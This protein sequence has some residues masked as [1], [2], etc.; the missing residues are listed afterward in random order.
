MANQSNS[1]WQR[2]SRTGAALHRPI[3][4]GSITLTD[5]ATAADAAIDPIMVVDAEAVVMYA[6]RAAHELVGTAN[7]V[8]T[9]ISSA[10]RVRGGHEFVD[11]LGSNAQ[12][13][14]ATILPAEGDE[15]EAELS[16]G[17]ADSA[18]NPRWVVV[19]HPLPR[20]E[21]SIREMLRRATHDDLTALANRTN[22]L[23]S[24]DATLK[25]PRTASGDHVLALIDLDG[26]KDINDSW[27]HEV[28]DRVLMEIG[29]RLRRLCRPGDVVA[30]LGGDEFAAWC[31]WVDPGDA[32]KL[33]TRL[34]SMF[35]DP[36]ASLDIQLDVKGSIGLTM[37]TPDCDSGTLLRR[38]D[39][40]MYDAKALGKGRYSF[41]DDE[42]ASAIEH[43]GRAEE[44]FRRAL[45]GNE[46]TLHY[47]PVVDLT[48]DE[49]VGVEA[50]ARWEHP[51]RGRLPPGEFLPIAEATSLS[52]EL[53]THIVA[54][55]CRQL[56]RWNEEL[57]R[58]ISMWINVSPTHLSERLVGEL[59]RLVVDLTL[60][61]HAIVIELTED[62]TSATSERIAVLEALHDFGVRIAIDDFG[63]GYSQLSYLPELPLDIVKLDR[64]FVDGIAAEPKRLAL[65]GS[66]I[67]L[68]HA[69][70]AT[71]VAEG[72]EVQDDLEAVRDLGCDHAQG[73]LLARPAAPE[74]VPGL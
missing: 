43:R 72:V 54:K 51:E 21:L 49:V 33:A 39:T 48:T 30:R 34:V 10:L 56:A 61:P 41:F 28:G 35:D 19:A 65:A 58:S 66:V 32:E 67:Q 11:L 25:D 40:A 4:W 69:I 23:E 6:N 9:N 8:R 60:D 38:A 47:Q 14:L 16:I 20:E 5:A 17:P 24:I 26:F 3:S 18:D 31:L 1:R 36:V 45:K 59:R 27:G 29:T 2:R 71:V 46:I 62:A 15:F 68:A 12:R 74:D 42:M 37:T 22:L 53:D 55:A 13:T 63:T 73:F 50:L 70:G 52:G 64:S 44:E 57:D 7:L